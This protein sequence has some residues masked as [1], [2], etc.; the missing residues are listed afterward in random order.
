MLPIL[1]PLFSIL[2]VAFWAIG[3]GVL[4]IILNETSLGVF[5]AIIGGLVLIVVVPTVAPFANRSS[6][7][8]GCP[9]HQSF[10]QQTT[11]FQILQ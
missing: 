5:G 4:F 10:G 8:F 2:G 9:N 6:P 7:K 3:L 1:L 11:A